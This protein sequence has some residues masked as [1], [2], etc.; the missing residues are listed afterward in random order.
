[1]NR[2]TKLI[3]PALAASLALGAV[4][5]AT[6]AP[7]NNG[8][9]VR[10]QI[11]QLDRKIDQAERQHRLTRQ[12]AQRLGKL[13]DQVQTLQARYARNGFTRA[14]L[15]SLDVRID[16]VS[17]QIDREIADRGGVHP[18]GPQGPIGHGPDRNGHH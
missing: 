1:M 15:R 4:T 18:G 10:Q 16:T 6:A 7:F 13:V 11:V 3:V 12:E 5:P 8:N 17:R 14:E 9:G 2:L